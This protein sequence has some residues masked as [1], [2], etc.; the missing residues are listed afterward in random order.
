MTQ[1]ERSQQFRVGIFVVV[2][3]ILTGAMIYVLGERTQIFE[4]Q[5][6][7]IA[8]FS[9]VGGLME[10]AMVRL[11][12]VPVG[13]VSRII[14]PPEAASQKVWVE[15]KIARHVR[16]RVRQ[17]SVARLE[18]AGL[19]GDKLIEITMG[20]ADKPLIQPGGRI[21]AV[22]PMD[23]TP[24]VSKG[25]AVLDQVSAVAAGLSQTL[26]AV[27]EARLPTLASETLTAVRELARDVKEGDGLLHAMIYDPGT[28]GLL[29]GLD[30]AARDLAEGGQSLSRVAKRVE[31]GDG[32]L[33]TLIYEKEP[34]FLGRLVAVAAAA[35]RIAQ[36]IERGDGLLPALLREP[37][38]R[39]AAD[40]FLVAAQ[41]FRQ[42]AADLARKDS[43]LHRLTAD[44]EATGVVDDLRRGARG[45]ASLGAAV[46]GDRV[47]R[48]LRDLNEAAENL[49]AISRDVAQGKGTL[50]ALIEDPTLYENLAAL[51][52]GAK[53]SFIL[54]SLIRSTIEKGR[55]T[56][57]DQ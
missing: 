50:G 30:K 25:E 4:R 18:T 24:L 6:P 28:K 32:F 8:E 57:P 37:K 1:S 54:R 40:E 20:G 31:E 2:L 22:D 43:L 21:A 19:L 16:E 14:F 3:L 44:P 15:M 7:I 47:E 27:R 52:E 33:H 36:Q 13:R 12:G 11:A 29:V 56:R 26:T 38:Y 42:F 45:V 55:E 39:R 51:L 46:E 35:E 53:R 34:P 41:D 48:V 10:G 5:Y 17:D 9:R 23:L 49:R